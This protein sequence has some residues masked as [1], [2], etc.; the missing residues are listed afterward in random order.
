MEVAH[1]EVHGDDDVDVLVLPHPALPQGLTQ[2]PRGEL[3]HHARPLRE[4]DELVGQDEP[5]LGVDP[6]DEGL[7]SRHAART[8]ERGRLV[9][10]NEAAALDRLSQLAH[11]AQALGAVAVARG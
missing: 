9:V 7:D 4:G 2:H 5:A 10:E 11:E 8:N 3:A 1:R 6:T